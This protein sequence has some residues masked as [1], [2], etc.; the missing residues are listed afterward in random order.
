VDDVLQV[1]QRPSKAVDPGDHQS[2]ALTEKLEQRCQLLTAIGAG[3]SYLLG[4][5]HSTARRREGIELDGQIL[6]KGRNASVPVKHSPT[7]KNVSKR[8]ASILESCLE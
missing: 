5:H 3:A 4:S 1:A 8:Y 2:V 6:I 7:P